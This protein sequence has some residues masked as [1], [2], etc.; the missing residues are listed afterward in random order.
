[1]WC[2]PAQMEGQSELGE[3]FRY[4]REV[5][6]PKRIMIDVISGKSASRYRL[7]DCAKSRPP[8]ARA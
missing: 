2:E 1:M 5:D 7:I 6:L 4:M 8:S 3:R